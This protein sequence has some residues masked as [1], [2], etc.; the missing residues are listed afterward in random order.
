LAINRQIR[1]FR[2]LFVVNL[3]KIRHFFAILFWQGWRICNYFNSALA[4]VPVSC[5]AFEKQA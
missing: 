5:Y 4:S 2:A 1:V 3:V